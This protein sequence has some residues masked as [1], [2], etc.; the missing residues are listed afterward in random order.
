MTGQD[1]KASEGKSKVTLSPFW[2]LSS[3][4]RARCSHYPQTHWWETPVT[5]CKGRDEVDVLGWGVTEVPA[6][7]GP[8]PSTHTHTHTLSHTHTHAHSHTHTHTHSHIH[9]H[10]YTHTLTDTHTLTHT[11]SHTHTPTLT[12]T[13][14]HIHTHSLSPTWSLWEGPKCGAHLWQPQTALKS[15]QPWGWGGGLWGGF[16]VSRLMLSV[17]IGRFFTFWATREDCF[18][19]KYDSW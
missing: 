5:S 16:W 7:A 12:H 10:T 6:R 9:S 19:H 13:H 2:A 17:V 14:S 3:T 1:Y 11:H 4:L 15:P 8:D 18:N